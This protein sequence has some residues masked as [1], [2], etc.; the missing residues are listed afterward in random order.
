MTTENPSIPL[1]AMRA[2]AVEAI[3][4]VTG[5]PD[6]RGNEGRYLVDELEAV[7]KAAA[8]TLSAEANPQDAQI[9][10]PPL[11]GWTFNHTQQ[12]TDEDGPVPGTWEIG[13]L[14]DEDDTFSPV[15]VLDTWLY[16][17]EDMAEPLARAI[18][19]RLAP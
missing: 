14:D 11:L 12:Q 13:W 4:A 6:L 2:I 3:R 5:C 8:E 10:Q 7:A 19:A 16:N 15:L 17:Q 9:V 18:L 1:S